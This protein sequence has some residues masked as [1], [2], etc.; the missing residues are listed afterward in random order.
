MELHGV[1]MNMILKANIFLRICSK[2][3]FDGVSAVAMEALEWQCEELYTDIDC[4]L[5]GALIMTLTQMTIMR[6]L[7]LR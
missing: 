4:H 7:K 2:Y 5:L 3:H 1:R 6:I